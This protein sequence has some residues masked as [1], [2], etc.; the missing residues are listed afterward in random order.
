MVN[1]YAYPQEA[2]V[3]ATVCTDAM[4]GST[5]YRHRNC[6]IQYH[7]YTPTLVAYTTTR[8][9][10][11]RF[12]HWTFSLRDSSVPVNELPMKI[13]PYK[14]LIWSR[15]I[16]TANPTARLARFHSS[17]I[18]ACRH[19][20][21]S[22]IGLLN[23][24]ALEVYATNV[25]I[26]MMYIIINEHANQAQQSFSPHL[27]SLASVPKTYYVTHPINLN[28]HLSHPAFGTICSALNGIFWILRWL[29]QIVC[30][31]YS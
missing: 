19:F 10:P 11:L 3:N 16:H 31:Q 20:G 29:Q 6:T 1:V 22:T 28:V 5:V 14:Y 9:T 2:E 27:L 15:L 18:S 24:W 21:P 8:Y 25:I 23:V 26:P 30:C 4:Y 17:C 7:E 13:I 12:G